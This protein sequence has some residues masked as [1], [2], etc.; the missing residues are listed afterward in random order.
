MY[1]HIQCVKNR[2]AFF[3]CLANH[4]QYIGLEQQSKSNKW[5]KLKTV[6]LMYKDG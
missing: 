1:S 3:L 6:S 2:F 4:I 5:R